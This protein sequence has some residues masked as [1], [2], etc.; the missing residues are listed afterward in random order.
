MSTKRKMLLILC[1]FSLVALVAVIGVFAFSTQS[2]SILNRIYFEDIIT[3]VQLDVFADISIKIE[4]KYVEVYN[5]ANALSFSDEEE[6]SNKAFI[7]P[8]MAFNGQGEDNSIVY[9]ITVENKSPVAALEYAMTDTTIATLQG[10]NES[11]VVKVEVSYVDS[12][13]Y[14]HFVD[15]TSISSITIPK[16]EGETANKG[17]FVIKYYLTIDSYNFNNEI[18]LTFQLEAKN[19]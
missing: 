3:P 9:T 10:I 18:D 6:T 5:M 16:K 1:S 12:N 19:N 15:L 2:F 11:G 8:E 4:N 17:S 14:E 13:D 7:P